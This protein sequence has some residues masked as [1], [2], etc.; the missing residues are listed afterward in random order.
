M[1]SFVH[2]EKLEK[3]YYN[4]SNDIF[5]AFL[6]NNLKSIF[7]FKYVIYLYK[8]LKIITKKVNIIIII[9]IMYSHKL[10]Y[11]I[12]W[13]NLNHCIHH[14]RIHI[15]AYRFVEVD[16]HQLSSTGF[17]TF[18]RLKQTPSVRPFQSAGSLPWLGFRLIN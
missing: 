1:L 4:L 12:Q 10:I 11:I 16:S 8:Y 17:A 13:I 7:N 15:P 2:K 18:G 5:L 14:F 3:Y 9:I 6:S